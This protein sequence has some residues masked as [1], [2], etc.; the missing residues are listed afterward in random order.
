MQKS[1]CVAYEYNANIKYVFKQATIIIMIQIMN[2]LY[3]LFR[4]LGVV[5]E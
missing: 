1:N 5:I 2:Y 4:T 3:P